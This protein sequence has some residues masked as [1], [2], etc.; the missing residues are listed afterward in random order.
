MKKRLSLFLAALALILSAS[1]GVN[2]T[3][4]TAGDGHPAGRHLPDVAG[5]LPCL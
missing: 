1:C 3:V 2:R 4:G 5:L